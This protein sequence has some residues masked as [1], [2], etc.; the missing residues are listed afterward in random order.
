MIIVK[1][2]EILNLNFINVGK[3]VMFVFMWDLF[4]VIVFIF[5]YKYMDEVMILYCF[6]LNCVVLLVWEYCWVIV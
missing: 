1:I 6:I 4:S 2:C 3:F 5:R